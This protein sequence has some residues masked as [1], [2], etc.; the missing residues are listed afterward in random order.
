MNII[1]KSNFQ[2][3]VTSIHYAPN[4]E[5]CIELSSEKGNEKNRY[6]YTANLGNGQSEELPS[7]NL[8]EYTRNYVANSTIKEKSKDPY[9]Q[10]A[11]FLEAYGDCTIDKITTEYLQGFIS[12]LQTEDN[13]LTNVVDDKYYDINCIANGLSSND[14]LTIDMNEVPER[15]QAKLIT[16]YDK[17]RH[18]IA[19]A[20]SIHHNEPDV[21]FYHSDH[22]GSASWITDNGGLAVQHLQYLPYGERYVDQRISGYSERFTFIGKEKDCET[23][24]YAFG[25][26]YYDCDLSGLFLSVDPMSDKYPSLSPYAYCAW[27]P[28]KLVDPNGDSIVISGTQEQQQELAKLVD[29]FKTRLP[30]KYD[31]LNNSSH[32][33]NIQFT[34]TNVDGSGGCFTYNYKTGQYDVGI[35]L[36]K[37]DFSNIEIMAHELRHAEQFEDGYLGF[38]VEL[39]TGKVSPYAYDVIDEIEA[40]EQAEL[41]AIQPRTPK[42]L[43]QDV[44][45]L[46]SDL[47]HTSQTVNGEFRKNYPLL[48]NSPIYTIEMHNEMHCKAKMGFIYKYNAIK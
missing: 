40:A 22:L 24:Y 43:R 29:E 6:Q 47:P 32:T 27:N 34:E 46:Y 1:I 41:F 4:G 44:E 42:K 37:S 10:M 13:R 17:F 7:L 5:L 18:T 3:S 30:G 9:N 12:H 16:D 35:G 20:Q 11:R 48:P 2:F 15:L 26:R 21:Y 23:G 45:G 38:I 19:D 33:Y 25:A 8:L 39:K 36:G 14:K 28:V 31:K